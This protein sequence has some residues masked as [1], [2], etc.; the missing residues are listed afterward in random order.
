M[1]ASSAPSPVCRHCGAAISLDNTR[2][3]CPACVFDDALTAVDE[4]DEGPLTLNDLGGEAVGLGHIGDFQ[5]L[6]QVARGG[7]GVVYLARQSALDRPVALKLLVAGIHASPEARQ[8]FR[9]EARLAAQ[10]QHPNIVPILEVGECQGQAY[11]AMEYVDGLDLSKVAAGRPLPPQQAA[12]Y[13]SAVADAIQHAHSRNVLHRDLKPPNILIGADDRPRVTDFGLARSLVTDSSLTLSGATLGTPS[14]LPPEQVSMKCGEVG[15]ASDVYA[16]GAILYELLTGRPPFLSGTVAD[17]LRAVVELDPVPPRTL[18]PAVPQDLEVITLKCLEKSSARR[19]ATAAALSQDLNAFLRDEPISASPPSLVRR[20]QKSWHRHSFAYLAS[21]TILTSIL[22]ATAV[23]TRALLR[24][25][26]AAR[27]SDLAART[28]RHVADFLKNMLGSI[29]PS[30]AGG[31]DTSLLQNLL[32]TTADRVEQELKDEPLVQAE[33]YQSLGQAYSSLDSMPEAETMFRRALGIREAQLGSL[34]PEFA[35]SLYDLGWALFR[36]SQLDDAEALLNRALE[37]RIKALGDGDPR[38]IPILS[39]LAA[40]QLRKGKPHEAEHMARKVLSHVERIRGEHHL[41][42]AG[43]LANLTSILISE[44]QFPEAETLARRALTIHQ[45][46][47]TMTTPETAGVI[48]VLGTALSRQQKPQEAEPLL[49]QAL[50]IQEKLLA[51][52]DRNLA[53]TRAE[54]GRVCLALGRKAEARILLDSALPIL[55]DILG[56]DHPLVSGAR[57]ARQEAGNE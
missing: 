55:T 36:R 21:G 10:L 32:R 49:R 43:A 45:E 6:R 50:A 42:T 4:K 28:S 53:T 25:R 3:L 56:P 52:N 57:D 34:H 38:T 18:N 9:L 16:L 37:V 20:L 47:E 39:G 33:L 2:R 24:E 29:N 12:R 22:V 40:I 44:G 23:A 54:L 46:S 27:Q 7:M 31:R 30:I 14:Y 26:Q 5:L 51:P 48:R 13:A 17:T 11:I 19:Y 41:H 8:R 1:S 35:D 15:P